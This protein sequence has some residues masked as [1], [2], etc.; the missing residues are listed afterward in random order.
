[1]VA[2]P[3]SAHPLS[4][5][6]QAGG[7]FG[8]Q[9][10]GTAW[11]FVGAM[12]IAT[13]SLSSAAVL[14]ACGLAANVVGTLLW[15][16]R[17]RLDPYRALQVLAATIVFAGAIATRWLELRGEFQ[18]LDPRVSPHTMYVMLGVLWLG[19]GALFAFKGRAARRATAA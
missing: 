2:N 18:L 3:R 9:L 14:A 5:H 10:G 4:S 8:S 16:Q 1:M 12:V 7:W 15:S 13:E 6:W 19:L 11:L 17:T